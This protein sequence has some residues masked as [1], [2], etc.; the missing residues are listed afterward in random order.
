MGAPSERD[1]VARAKRREEALDS[2]GFEREREEALT[3]RLANAVR[4][5]EAWRVDEEAFGKME[6]EEI[7]VLRGVGFSAAE[8]GE[9]SRVRLEAAIAKLEAEIEESRSRQR[10]F[11]RYAQALEEPLGHN[12]S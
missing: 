10:A 2:L 12:A 3:K 7:E 1:R 6:A 9:E 8:P 4:D 11:G 5:L